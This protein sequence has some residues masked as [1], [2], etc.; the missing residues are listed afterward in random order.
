MIPKNESVVVTYLNK[1]GI[2]IALLTKRKNEDTYALYEVGKEVKRLGRGN[3]PL[4]LEV[5]YSINKR[6]G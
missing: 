3:N 1:S 6:M 5:K 2:V 4:E